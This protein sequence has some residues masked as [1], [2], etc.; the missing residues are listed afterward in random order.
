MLWIAHGDP[1][2]RSSPSGSDLQCFLPFRIGATIHSA[3]L[4]R[5]RDA[6]DS[7]TSSNLTVVI[8][9]FA[10]KR[11]LIAKDADLWL[12][13]AVSFCHQA[14]TARFTASVCLVKKAS[15]FLLYR[16]PGPGVAGSG[17]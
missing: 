6:R 8:S 4:R 7:W 2:R 1:Q 11:E 5:D 12:P 15:D 16:R 3:W 14:R 10:L 17:S 13:A 9:G